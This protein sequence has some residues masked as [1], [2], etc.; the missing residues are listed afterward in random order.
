MSQT[1]TIENGVNPIFIE[2]W[3]PRAYD[4]SSLSDAEIKPLFEAARWAPSA[5]N[6]QPWR[7]IYALRD[8]PQW[9]TF[10]NLLIPYN[11]GWAEHA[12][13]LV[14][15]ISA[16]KFVPPGKTEAINTGYQSY[17]TGAAVAY[18]ALQASLVGLGAHIVAGFD[19][20]E[21]KR[22]LGIPKSF[23]VES[24]IVI[25][26]KGRPEVLSPDLR[27]REN[28]TARQP[29]QSL[30]AEGSFNFSED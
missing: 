6:A 21:T 15:A 20:E 24:A 16:Q 9:Q 23:H 12:S 11:R 18:L 3:S 14:F 2:R 7:F 30:V 25:G 10:L 29:L 5:Y 4:E 1:R 13:A 26:R 17:D 19:K 28:P 8:T 22:V 27:A